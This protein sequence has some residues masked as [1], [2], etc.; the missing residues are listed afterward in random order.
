MV[1][2]TRRGSSRI[3]SQFFGNPKG[4]LK[5]ALLN[6][7]MDMISDGDDTRRR[8]QLTL[9]SERGGMVGV[10]LSKEDEISMGSLLVNGVRS[11]R[12]K[13]VLT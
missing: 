10:I 9:S 1:A 11:L 6:R 3:F 2:P 7:G 13:V 12:Q 4:E 8:M 5:W